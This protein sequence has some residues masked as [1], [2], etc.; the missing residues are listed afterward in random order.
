MK[1]IYSNTNRLLRIIALAI[2]CPFGAI[3]DQV[4]IST[5]PVGNPGNASDP[6]TRFGAVGYSYRIAKFDVTIG[7]YTAFLNA[8]ARSDPHGLYNKK[9]ATDLLVAGVSRSGKSGRFSYAAIPPG[10]AVQTSAASTENRPI[11]YVSWFDAA[12]F[13]NWMANG[14]PSGRQTARTTENGAYN[15]RAQ[16]LS[17]TPT[18]VGC[19]DGKTIRALE[20]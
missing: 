15:R 6:A 18:R 2:L 8:V 14:Q 16:K 3:A 1:P 5:I 17:A 9:M 12:R 19:W 10:G 20:A 4:S 13:A 11:T 7:Q